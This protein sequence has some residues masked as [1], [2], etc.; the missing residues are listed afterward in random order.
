LK[1]KNILDLGLLLPILT[2]FSIS[3]IYYFELG[4][5]KFFGIPRELIEIELTKSCYLIFL[6]FPALLF[7]TFIV[8]PP[9]RNLLLIRSFKSKAVKLLLIAIFLFIIYAAFKD[10]RK[11]ISHGEV[12]LLFLTLLFGIGLLLNKSEHHAAKSFL[13]DF[14]IFRYLANLFGEVLGPILISA[15]LICFIMFSVGYASAETKDRFYSLNNKNNVLLRKYSN[16]SIF[17]INDTL[18]KP[19]K[20]FVISRSSNDS[21]TLSLTN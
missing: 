16:Y 2:I 8:E 21:D 15:S 3:S 1:G 11:F 17:A 20:R 5:F 19:F 13:E 7:V 18:Q 9:L 10:F 14:S 4:Y 6:F 12:F